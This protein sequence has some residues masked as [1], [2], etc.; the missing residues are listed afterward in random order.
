MGY[1]FAIASGNW[2]NPL[3]WNDGVV[4]SSVDTVYSNS[5]T[6]VIDQNINVASLTN[7]TPLYYLQNQIIPL[8]TSNVSPSGLADATTNSSNAYLAF[9]G[10]RTNYWNS[11]IAN[12]GILIYRFDTAKTIKRYSFSK[13]NYYSPKNWTFEA[14]DDGTNWTVL[15]TVTNDTGVVRYTSGDIG[16]TTG[17]LY[18]RINVTANVAPYETRMYSFEMSEEA[19]TNVFGTVASG[20]FNVNGSIDIVFN[21]DGIAVQNATANANIV[22]AIN[23]NSPDI[24]NLSTINGGYILGPNQITTVNQDT[25]ALRTYGTCTLNYTGDVYSPNVNGY[26]RNGNFYI[27]GNTIVNI[28][29]NIYGPTT[30]DGNG[31]IILNI[32]S[33]APTVNITGNIYGAVG[34]VN[35]RAIQMSSANGILNV[36]GNITTQLGPGIQMTAGILNHTGIVQV[37][38]G[39]S[40]PA[41]L[42]TSTNIS[43][44][45][46]P[47]I[48]YNGVVAVSAYKMQFYSGS[49]V[50]WLFQDS[51]NTNLNLYS[52][53]TG[54]TLGL[55]L[56]TDVRNGITFGAD[57]N[58]SG[59]LVVPSTSNVRIGVPVDN[60]VG[61]ADLTTEDIFD[62]IANSNNPIAVRLR[63]VATVQTTATTITS[64]NI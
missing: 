34:H 3:T 14:S 61:T 16:N 45:T 37:L 17:Y 29:G 13:G 57:G 47:F 64:F 10:N 30:T 63:N 60:T 33:S 41:V 9:N 55:P 7:L 62:A 32:I 35:N 8:M 4:P 22:L 52:G 40:R 51:S 21:G 49:T 59:T 46:S 12:T 31:N 1:K 54:S 27:G 39:N 44:F 56:T 20:K 5:F 58:L 50:Q 28:I 18:Y 11:G 24:V 48:N 26:S 36:T 19:T 25:T 38:N 23:A 15:H 6:V 43:K 2:S 42:S 53:I